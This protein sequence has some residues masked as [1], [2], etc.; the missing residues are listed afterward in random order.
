[1]LALFGA[2]GSGIW[3]WYTGRW[4]MLLVNLGLD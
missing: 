2:A 3:L 4:D 1:M